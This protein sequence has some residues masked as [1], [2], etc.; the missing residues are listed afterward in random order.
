MPLSPWLWNMDGAAQQQE[1][2]LETHGAKDQDGA[3]YRGGTCRRGVR[4]CMQ[5]YQPGNG[6]SNA[7]G[8]LS[9]QLFPEKHPSHVPVLGSL[10]L[11]FVV[12][13]PFIVANLGVGVTFSTI[14]QNQLQAVQMS[15]FFFLPSILLSGFM[16]P[17]RGM[18]EWAQWVGSVLPLTHFLR[19]VRGIVLKGN[20]FVDILPH[21]WPICL[22][23]LVSIGFG[24]KRYRQTLD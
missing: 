4:S 12:A 19:V 17:F 15:F 18:P 24:V 20:S 1:N 2:R 21:L 10:P 22:F 7:D 3:S 16:F 13:F 5:D 8:S 9:R 14:A 23:L 6:D 11:L